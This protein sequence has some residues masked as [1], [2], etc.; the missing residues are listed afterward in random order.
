M[1]RPS[2]KSATKRIAAVDLF[3]GAGGLTRGFLDAGIPVL[4][5]YDIDSACQFAYEH[6]NTGAR[7]VAQSVADLFSWFYGHDNQLHVL[8]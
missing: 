1:T 6:N 3:C 7:F 2:N 4:A 5:G 8:K